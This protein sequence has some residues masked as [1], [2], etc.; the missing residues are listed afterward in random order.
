MLLRKKIFYFLLPVISL[1]SCSGTHD[2]IGASFKENSVPPAP[3]YNN[4]KYWAALPD[5]KDPADSVPNNQFE[6]N[7]ATAAADVFFIHPT[8]FTSK[9]KNKFEWNADLNDAELNQKTDN[10]T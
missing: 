9:Q 4:E 7:E 6:N 2:I 1:S 5:K 8:T 10:S 3:D